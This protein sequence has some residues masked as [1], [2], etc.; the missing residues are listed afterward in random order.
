M[1]LKL[2]SLSGLSQRTE[3][4]KHCEHNDTMRASGGRPWTRHSLYSWQ[5][6]SCSAA[7]KD[8]VWNC[9]IS[10]METEDENKPLSTIKSFVEL[11]VPP[12]TA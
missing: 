4:K 9:F 3:R 7:T 2:S 10:W 12:Q 1:W 11:Y 6:Y 5:I 8:I